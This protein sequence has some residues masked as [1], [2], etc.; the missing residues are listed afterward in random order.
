MRGEGRDKTKKEQAQHLG[1]H[2]RDITAWRLD[3][4]D[5]CRYY[6]SKEIVS[7]VLEECEQ[8]GPLATQRLFPNVRVSSIINRYRRETA[9]KYAVWSAKEIVHAS[10]MAGIIDR[11]AQAQLLPG[12]KR[13]PRAIFSFWTSRCRSTAY[14]HGLTRKMGRMVAQKDCPIV[15]RNGGWTVKAK[16]KDAPLKRMVSCWIVLWCDLERHLKPCVPKGIA[17]AIRCMAE[18][19]RWIF[20]PKDPGVAIRKMIIKH[21]GTPQKFLSCTLGD[22]Q[23]QQEELT[24]RWSSKNSRV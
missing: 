6:Y 7:A 2:V 8:R 18:Y 10:R 12:Q 13:T 9:R 19:Q 17:N 1:C 5:A 14:L 3:Q 15:P 22:T 20:A 21:N 16:K 23:T 11:N 24:W 4:K